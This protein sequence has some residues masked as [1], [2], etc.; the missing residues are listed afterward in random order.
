[1]F[2][3]GELDERGR[4]KKKELGV[5]V[6]LFA[7]C[8]HRFGYAGAKREIIMFMESERR[9]EKREVNEGYSSGKIVKETTA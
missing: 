6:L 9:Q 3:S 5:V 2:S 1:V 4:P 7:Q 8:K